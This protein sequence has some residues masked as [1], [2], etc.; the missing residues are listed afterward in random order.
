M[1]KTSFALRLIL[2]G[3][4]GLA[5]LHLLAQNPQHLVFTG[6]RALTDQSQF[7]AVKTDATGNLYLLLDQKDGVRLLKTDPTTTNIL[8]ETQL[9][10]HGDIGLAMALDPTGNIYITGTTASGTLVGTSGA[11]FP[12]AADASTNSFIA[13]FD[14]N[15]NSIFLTYAGSGRTAATSIAATADAVFITGST[16]TTTLPVTPSAI[17]QT[18][19]SGSFQNGFVEKFNAT[20]TTLLYATYL[21]AFNGD[22]APSAI[23]ADTQDNAYITGYTTSSGYP[24]LN[25]LIPEILSTTSGFLT[26]L[27]PAGDSILFSTFI[28]GTGPTSLALDPATQNLLLS[29]PID[30]G[31]FPITNVQTPLVNTTYQTLI[32]LPLD[33]STVL[34][35]TLLAPGTQSFV[36]PAPN[37]A[38][39]ITGPLTFPLLPT[40]TLSTIG[41]TYAL[42]VNAQNTIDQ[43]ARFGALPTNN[44]AFSTAP[45][46][47]TSLTTDSTGQLILAGSVTP[48]TSSSLIPTQTYNLTLSPPTPALPSTLRNAILNQ[49]ICNG[50]LCVGSAAFLTKLDPATSTPSLVLSTDDSPNITLRNLGSSAATNLQIT[51]TG[52]TSTDSCTTNLA[53]GAE[54]TIALTGTGPGALTIAA[55]NTPSQTVTILATTATSNPIALSTRELDLGIQT[56]ATGAT[57]STPRAITVTNLTQQPQTF[58]SKL[59]GAASPNY[60]ITE[61]SAGCPI[62]SPNTRFISPGATCSIT[63]SLTPHTD[64]P[65]S[66]NW[67]IGTHDILLT[68]YAQSAALTVSTPHI[69]FGT[70]YTNGIHLP[71]YLY[72]S[73]NSATPVSH[74]LV[75]LPP[76]SP[77]TLTDNCPSTLEPHTVCQLQLTY[78]SPQ[79]STDSTTLTLD[80]GLIVLV[81]GKTIPQPGVNGSITNPNLAVTPSTINFPDA[82]VVADLSASTQNVTISNTGTQPFTLSLTLFGDFT[83]TTNCPSTLPGNVTCTVTLAFAPSAPGTRQGLL[84]V[85]AGA[86]T[87]PTYVTLSG[88]ATSILPSNNGTLDFGSVIVGQPSI[89]WYKITQPFSTLTAA[90]STADYTAILI[91]DLGYGHGQPPSSAFTSDTTGP[92]TNCWLGIQFKP[93]A[94]GSRDATLTLASGTT[95]NPYSLALTGTGLALIGLQLTPTT[96]DFGPAPIHSTTAPTL[97]TL[98]NLS[99]SPITLTSTTLTGDFALSTAP[100]GGPSCTGTLVPTAS[101]FLQITFSPTAQNQRAGT[102][103]IDTS[104]GT[105]TSTLSGFGLPDPGFSINPTALIFNNIPDPSATQ[106]TITITNTSSSAL[107]GIGYSLTS[108]HF[109]LDQPFLTSCLSI[110]P[111]ASC[112]LTIDFQPTASTVTGSLTINTVSTF[113]NT[114]ASYTVPLT[115][116]YTT[117]DTGLQIIPNQ[118][119]YGPTPTSTLGLARQFTINNLTT[120]SLNLN[121]ALP[122][123]FV[124]TSDPCTTLAPSTSC[125][126]TAAFLPLTNGDITGTLFAQA[127]PTDGTPTFNG[128]GY[129]EGYG[130]GTS[131]LAITGGLFPGDLLNFNQVTSGQTSSKT[132][133]LTNPGTIPITIRRITSEWPFLSTTTCGSTLTS[134]QSCTVTINYTPLFQLASGIPSP[135]PAADA[136]TLVIES[137]AA[138]SPELIDLSG[139]AAPILVAAPANTAPL[140]SFTTSQGSLTFPG[141]QIGNASPTQTVT[142]TNTGTATIHIIGTQT[143]PDFTITSNCGTLVAGA[144]CTLTVAFTPQASSITPTGQRISAI[145]ITS[146]SS[147][148]LE[149]ISLLGNATPA[150]LV[151]SPTSLDFGSV[152]VGSASTLPIQITNV[153]TTPAIFNAI[154]TTGDYT[155][156]G[157]CPSPGN[158]LAPSATCTIQIAF[159]PAQPGTR[160]GTLSLNTSLTSLPLTAALTGIGAQSQLQISPSSLNFGSVTVGTSATLPLTLAN[161]G[162]ASLNSLA[163][164]ISGDYTIAAPCAL[165]T[166]AP[167]SSCSVTI[168]FA[169]TAT[170]TRAGTLTVASTDRSSPAVV[171]L[172]GTGKS[173]TTTATGTFTLT[174][175]GGNTSTITVKSGEPASYNLALTPQDNFAGTVVLNCT[176]ITPGQYATCSLLPSSVILN[177]SSQNAIATINTVTEATTAANHTSPTTAFLC[178][179]PAAILFF[180]QSTRSKHLRSSNRSEHPGQLK[181][182]G[183]RSHPT[184]WLSMALITATLFAA[185][186]GSGGTLPKDTSSTLRYT[187]PGTYQYQVTASSTTG[188]KLT[189][190]VTLN[191]VVTAQ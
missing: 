164:G 120:K 56:P 38:A 39:W 183:H 117:E 65:I 51:A 168:T 42:R 19:L 3:L 92:C 66:V 152:L 118:A 146:D 101:C 93:S 128:I 135:L 130:V 72:L 139:N 24:T 151:F 100:T 167:G 1:T 94:T 83:D 160:T 18:P 40:P 175:G 145:E 76:T 85:S 107:Q 104:Y 102:L 178:L 17:I 54:C 41:N 27:A 36:T 147:T 45:V 186:C 6:L 68:A 62:A 96:P 157:T 184:L 91:E 97:F 176:P 158:V 78:Q 110:A 124:L 15:L 163:L 74:S 63:L 86:G 173:G 75:T 9:G 131:S 161:T 73:N 10:S 20:G 31:Q 90:S 134:N 82:V 122:R 71:R 80:Q 119:N 155:F 21:S 64:G 99:P 170:G 148:A 115:G 123:Q 116:A 105:I 188:Q 113:L 14:S 141:T 26:R 112:H 69:E 179:L 166:L 95:G 48:T 137:D 172:T 84:T 125:N 127:T 33:G 189:Q 165:T 169:P 57:F 37:G 43:T 162:T 87:T 156:T 53:P 67:L 182:T 181:P 34:S 58:T 171:A 77:F 108:S 149:F 70:Q 180:R 23:A 46:N 191:L 140:V 138:S 61:L 144:T 174:V 32:R 109:T 132:L 142:L 89:Q 114:P 133:T 81:T 153:S 11:I 12:T 55:T 7:N 30:L 159:T 25:A 8:A 136:G 47:P 177:G 29:G 143:T 190:T 106:Q 103:A 13:K 4:C 154:T 187:P 2:A 44:A 129:V 52:F 16:F 35:S 59:D 28:P 121:V 49:G 22:T 185:G 60:T 150:N 126:F 88:T 111:G 79:T 5:S 50:S 98:T